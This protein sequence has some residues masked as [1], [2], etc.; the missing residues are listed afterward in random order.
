MGLRVENGRLA[1]FYQP[2]SV[3]EL[4]FR[5]DNVK[6]CL[7]RYRLKGQMEATNALRDP[8]DAAVGGVRLRL[9]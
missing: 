2:E 1:I 4:S 5:T 9:P 6:F 8:D 7:E 3:K